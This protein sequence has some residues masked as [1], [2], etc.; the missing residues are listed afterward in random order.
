MSGEYRIF[1]SKGT[2]QAEL[3][4]D[5]GAV[6]TAVGDVLS[7]WR[8]FVEPIA[9]SVAAAADAVVSG[10]LHELLYERLDAHMRNE[11]SRVV[12]QVESCLSLL[13]YTRD[14]YDREQRI[15]LSLNLTGVP[16]SGL[17]SLIQGLAVDNLAWAT[18]K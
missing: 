14:Q 12:D 1:G 2:M 17:S 13:N 4:R 6:F 15:S 10:T 7:L 5:Y 8:Q 3:R 16:S 11:L 9:G 18:S